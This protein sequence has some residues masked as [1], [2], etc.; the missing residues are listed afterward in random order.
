MSELLAGIPKWF[1]SLLVFLGGA[2]FAASVVSGVISG[3]LLSLVITA[4][5]V[6]VNLLPKAPVA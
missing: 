2:G 3:I 6:V 4:L 1:G 5:G